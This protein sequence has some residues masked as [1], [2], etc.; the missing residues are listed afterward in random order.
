MAA[1]M[2]FAR[3]QIRA[4]QARVLLVAPPRSVG[5]VSGIANQLVEAIERA[6]EDARLVD[7]RSE[8]GVGAPSEL[9]SLGRLRERLTG[10]PGFTVAL[11]S[12]I[13]DDPASLLAAAVA[14]GVVVV[15]LAGRTTRADLAEARQEIERAGGSLLGGAMHC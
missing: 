4:P 13:L 12:G 5:D 14:D 11:G 10:A 15:A 9:P 8:G 2:L 3:L 1:G 7:V 6:G